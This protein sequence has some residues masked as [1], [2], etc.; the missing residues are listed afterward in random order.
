MVCRRLRL[1]QPKLKSQRNRPPNRQMVAGPVQGNFVKR[2]HGM[3]KNT[4]V[5]L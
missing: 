2:W 3:N 1:S 5:N 4:A